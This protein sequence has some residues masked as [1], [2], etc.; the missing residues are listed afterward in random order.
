MDAAAFLPDGVPS[1]WSVYFGTDDTD[2][3][4]VRIAELGGSVLEGAQDSPYGRLAT[5]AD[6][7]G[8]T[9]RVIQPPA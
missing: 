8:A 9:F 5:V 3:A 1:S 2:A 4:L 7:L 6:P